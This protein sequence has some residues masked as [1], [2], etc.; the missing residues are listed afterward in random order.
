MGT[1]E[2]TCPD[3]TFK[4]DWHGKTDGKKMVME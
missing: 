1:T 2:G 3:E 4:H